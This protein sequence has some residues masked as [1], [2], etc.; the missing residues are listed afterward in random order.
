MNRDGVLVPRPAPVALENLGLIGWESLAALAE[1]NPYLGHLAESIVNAYSKL[2]PF[3]KL[4][5]LIRHVKGG[6]IV[7]RL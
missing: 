4:W 2:D 7:M 5:V 1:P 6:T 3:A